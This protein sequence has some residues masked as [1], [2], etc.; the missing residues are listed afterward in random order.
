MSEFQKAAAM[1]VELEHMLYLEAYFGRGDLTKGKCQAARAQVETAASDMSMRTFDELLH[2]IVLIEL[3]LDTY[4]S[5][6]P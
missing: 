2:R 6:G 5:T 4:S 1:V 3:W